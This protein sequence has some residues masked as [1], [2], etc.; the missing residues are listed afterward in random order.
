MKTIVPNFKGKVLYVVFAGKDSSR[1]IEN[2][3]FER[4]CGRLFLVGTSPEDASEKDWITGL[5]YA[6]AWDSVI[7]YVVFN[8][9]EEYRKRLSTFYGKKKRTA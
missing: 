3:R 2:A 1:A 5:R 7:D 6:V 8:S 4:Q 9:F